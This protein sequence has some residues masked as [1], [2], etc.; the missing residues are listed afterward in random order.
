ML[1][2][3]RRTQLPTQVPEPRVGRQPQI[4][5]H[6]LFGLVLLLYVVF[7]VLYSLNVPAWEAPDEPA[8]FAYIHHIRT[9]GGPPVQSFVQGKNE[10]ETGHHPPLYYYVGAFF[11]LPFDL[12]DFSRI[13]TNR[14]FSFSNTD[15]G[16]NRFKQEGAAQAYPNTL[17]AVHT[18]RFGSILFGAGTLLCIYLSGLLVFGG[19][20]W[21]W[22]DKGRLP[23]ALAAAL[24]ALVPQFAFLSG[25]I[26]NDNAVVFFCA[27]G[28]YL[29][30]RIA[31]SRNGATG[32]QLRAKNKNSGLF[33][34][35]PSS[36]VPE[37][38]FILLGVVV[39]L[40]MLSK[41]NA[42]VLIPLVGLATAI[43]AWRRRSLRFFLYGG[44][45]SAVG[46]LAVSSWW[47]L[48]N[49]FLYGDPAGWSMWRSSFSSVDQSGKFQFSPD[50]LGHVW[51]RWFN[52]YWGYFGWFNL[53]F[54][55]EVYK[56]LA[57]FGALAALGLVGWL[58]SPFIRRISPKLQIAKLDE[59]SVTGLIFASLLLLMTLVM[60]FNY[61][62]TFGDA[63]TQGRYLYAALPTF[64]L[65]LGG[66]LFWLVS[67]LPFRNRLAGG[68]VLLMGVILAAS[69]LNWHA[70]SNII[71]PAYLPLEKVRA[72]I[73]VRDL[74]PDAIRLSADNI[75]APVMQLEGYT[76][77]TPRDRLIPGDLKVTFYW[78]ATG[79]TR[80]NWLPF[81]HLLNGD[82]KF[83][84]S[85]GAPGG[86]RY[87][88][89]NWRPGELIKD[90]RTLKIA[91]WQLRQAQQYRLPLVLYVGW[92]RSGDGARARLS[93]GADNIILQL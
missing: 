74:P 51:S 68:Y 43:A 80:D 49:Q 59:R 29:C 86:R 63:G 15:G 52:S 31:V 64:S 32:Y 85:D 1:L 9:T 62:A 11:T 8:H 46:C 21:A 75:F 89:Y 69:W 40:G 23:A 82:Q 60:A 28:F 56:W 20:T 10:V 19:A 71:R 17:A 18:V 87:Q 42:I 58:I 84:Q 72:E 12:S 24:T 2:D 77:S 37:R 34:L 57:R 4:F 70:V 92:F 5:S 35:Y 78:R 66:G 91:D 16:V 47:F 90:E 83:S 41:Y 50:W 22:A 44:V 27:L 14:Y 54:E 61:A 93:S 3:T 45:L 53:P 30:L 39:G 73:V 65:A 6:W 25:A 55:P 7:S 36:P 33:I 79:S 13:K 67:W 81:V 88:T 38:V 48:R 26:N 76:L